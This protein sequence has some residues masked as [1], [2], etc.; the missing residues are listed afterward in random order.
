MNW[1]ALFL[2]A[3]P[4]VVSAQSIDYAWLNQPCAFMLNCDTGCSACNS[5]KNAESWFAGTEPAWLGVDVCPQP[6]L[7]GDNALFTYGWPAISDE[8]H[9]LMISGFAFSP[10]RVDSLVFRHRSGT[11]GPQRVHVRFGVNQSLPANEIADLTVPAEFGV[12]VLTDLGEV[13]AGS[14]MLYGFFSL[15]L[16][17]YLGMDGPWVLD[18]LRIVG[19][20]VDIAMVVPDLPVSVRSSHLPKYDAMGRAII[21]RPGLGFY[22]DGAKRV[23]L[24]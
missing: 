7:P 2:V 20:P 10:M 5:P 16:Q 22:V 9:L 4:G 17:P 15:V 6:G 11:D 8:D 3:I 1:L 12:S 14:G 23:V 13:Q 18:D 21:D 24:R 19:S